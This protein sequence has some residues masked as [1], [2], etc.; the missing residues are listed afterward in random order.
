[1]D[2][3]CLPFLLQ[4]ENLV[5]KHMKSAVQDPQLQ[6]QLTPNFSI[7]CK[8][9]LASDDYY[10]ALAADNVKVVPAALKQVGGH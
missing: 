4:F 3:S 10:P 6:Q 1:L 8:R 7:G 5:L 9:I 2:C